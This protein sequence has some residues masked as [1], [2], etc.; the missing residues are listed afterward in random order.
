M[1]ADLLSK[2]NIL[3]LLRNL[4]RI[5]SINPS[6]GTNGG[7]GEAAIAEFAHTWLIERGV[8]AWLE[9]AAP[10]R[11]NAVARVGSDGG[12]TLVF[13][14]HI[15]TV[16]SSRMSIPPFDPKVEGNRVYGRGSYDMKGGVAA[17]MAAVAAL[18]ADDLQGSVMLALV[19]DEERSS[20]GADDFVRRHTADACIITEPTEGRLILTHKGFVW[21]ELVAVGT[22]AH[23]SRWDLGVSAVGRMGRVISALERFDRAVL[24]KR[25]HPDVGPASLHCS[26]IEGGVGI[27][28]Y[29]PDCRMQVERRTLPGETLEQVADEL[30]HV[31]DESGEE[32]SVNCFFHRSPL[33]CDREE[34]VARCV[35]DAAAEITG[36]V[37][38]ETGVAYWTDAAIFAAAGIPSLNYGPGGEGAHGAVEWVDIDSVVSCARVLTDAARRFCRL[39]DP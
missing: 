35:R 31:V 2:E 33:V 1:Q 36:S 23:G 38:E 10:G 37:P 30:E 28:T 13:C 4:I 9:E 5:P 19:V 11:P 22:A 24:R 25:T 7:T 29:A 15:D 6:L 12:P 26:I 18:Q 32:A 14:A 21:A 16:N 39:P 27:S 34:P 17:A 20:L 8:N 3:E